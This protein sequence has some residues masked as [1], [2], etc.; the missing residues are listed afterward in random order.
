[1]SQ[2]G[3][4][5]PRIEIEEQA[6]HVILHGDVDLYV[7]SD[8]DRALAQAIACQ[9]PAV[10]VDLAGVTFVD[11]TGIGTLVQGYHDA[12]ASGKG[13]CVTGAHGSVLRVLQLANVYQLLN[14]GLPAARPRPSAP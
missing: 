6:V 4:V 11:S 2:G 1:M 13:Y 3:V 9:R 5:Q 7:R 12:L 10:V 8:I 14:P